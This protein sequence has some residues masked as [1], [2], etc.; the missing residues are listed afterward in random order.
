MCFA[1]LSTSE[2]Q[3]LSAPRAYAIRDGTWQDVAVKELVPG[4]IIELKGGDVIPADCRVRQASQSSSASKLTLIAR[5]TM[6]S[7]ESRAHL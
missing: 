1:S 6:S 3:E 2:M 5:T 4:D 7:A